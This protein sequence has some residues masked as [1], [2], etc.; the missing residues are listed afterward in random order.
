MLS[1]SRRKLYGGISIFIVISA[2][3]LATIFTP[4]VKAEEAVYNWKDIT[5]PG[6]KVKESRI[7]PDGSK[8]IVLQEGA[9]FND[10]KLLL[11]TDGANWS[12]STAPEGAMNLL[13]NMDGSKLVV[14]G[15]YGQNN[16]H[17]ST[18][19]GNSWTTPAAPVESDAGLH[20]S[21]DGSTLTKCKHGGPL[22]VSRDNGQTWEQKG[23]ECPNA[24]FNNGK[25]IYMDQYDDLIKQSTDYGATWEIIK[26]G[27]ADEASFST[28]GSGIFN[29]TKL[30]VDGGRSWNSVSPIPGKSSDNKL[31]HL[32]VS[33]DGKRLFATFEPSGSSPTW[34]S[35]K[36]SIDGGKT[37][38]DWGNDIFEGGSISMI[39]DGSK[40]FAAANN[41]IYRLGTLQLP[42]TKTFDVSTKP[43]PANTDNAVAK[44]TIATKSLRCYD[45]VASSVK[46][47]SA[48]GITPTEA[49]VKILG[50]LSF[51]IN[52]TQVSASSNITISLAKQYDIAKMR[53]YKK[54]SATANL[55]DI[56]SQAV[57]KN[58]T[59]AG[60]TVTTISYIAVDGADNDDDHLANSVITDPIYFGVLEDSTSTGNPANVDPKAGKRSGGLADTGVSVWIFSGLAIA[61]VGG[62]IALKRY[63]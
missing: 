35:V 48:D 21:P 5:I 40:I 44:S 7:S 29:G 42:Q 9:T 37:W 3:S 62:G 58:E 33:D 52:C 55:Q 10:R 28:N 61:L 31:G 38:Q 4:F 26:D 24:V 47:L 46:P 20:M 2:V 22:H 34:R 13:T 51:K 56:T 45:I 36:T 17:V 25:M 54:D 11:S 49:R 8:L 53:V 19:G 12:S 59:I 16:I 50:G 60:K 1:R 43:A 15:K 57:I 30:S 41:N 27:A 63:M 23:N 18:D 39:A 32:G 6:G 14:K